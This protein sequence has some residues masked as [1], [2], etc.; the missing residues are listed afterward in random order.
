MKDSYQLVRVF[1]DSNEA[2][3]NLAAIFYDN[4]QSELSDLV[5]ASVEVENKHTSVTAC[6]IQADIGN[7]Y[8]VRCFNAENE[9][10]C[11]GHGM[12]AAAKILFFEN[13]LDEI[14]VNGNLIVSC[15]VAQKEY[16]KI[17]LSLPRLSSQLQEIPNWVKESICVDGK[18][19]FP[20]DSAISENNDGYLLF[21]FSP[22]LA[23]DVFSSLQLNLSQVCDN[24]KR[25]VVF[26]LFEE[27][28]KKLYMRY[29]APQ[30]G[31]LEDAA[32]GSVMRFVGDYI[33]QKYHCKH[34]EVIQC[35]PQG[36]YMIVDCK[37]EKIIITANATIET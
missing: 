8:Q 9:I 4:N 13:K 12:I 36:G 3:G 24:T 19:I 23:L 1:A 37:E 33:E 18:S 17:V 26:V 10:Q 15:D 30:Y 16:E 6:F 21:E 31:V 34:F 28:N 7:Q 5:E 20:S 11:C 35:S 22:R 27:K 25:A 2:Q 14:V 29:F 32:T